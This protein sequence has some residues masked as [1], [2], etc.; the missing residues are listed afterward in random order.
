MPMDITVPYKRNKLLVRL[1]AIAITGSPTTLFRSRRFHLFISLHRASRFARLLA[2]VYGTPNGRRSRCLL[3]SSSLCLPFVSIV[4]LTENHSVES[5]LL[6]GSFHE[7]NM[8][9]VDVESV[10]Y[11]VLWLFAGFLS[12]CASPIT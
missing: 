3:V 12:T 7:K 9:R 8:T 5:L 6:N 11:P 10:V 2:F 4:R 1:H